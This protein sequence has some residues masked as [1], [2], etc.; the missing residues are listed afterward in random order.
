MLP[1][2]HTAHVSSG[3]IFDSTKPS[4]VA[5]WW[6]AN[7]QIFPILFS[8]A[9]SILAIAQGSTRCERDFSG[10]GHTLTSQRHNMGAQ[11][12]ECE[13][14]AS[15]NGDVTFDAISTARSEDHAERQALQSKAQARR[16][17]ANDKRRRKRDRTQARGRVH[18]KILPQAVLRPGGGLGPPPAHVVVIEDDDKEEAESEEEDSED[19]AAADD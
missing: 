18:A 4:E 2:T 13:L 6:T 8:F 17:L 3:A 11:L 14:L 12:L 5:D 16:A 9:P 19:F 10:I 1:Q 7:Q 15:A